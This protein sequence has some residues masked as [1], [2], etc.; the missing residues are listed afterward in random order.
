[1]SSWV[2][3]SGPRDPPDHVPFILVLEKMSW[4]YICSRVYAT[5]FGHQRSSQQTKAEES[6]PIV[7][8]GKAG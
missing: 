8:S 4:R 3:K 2:K 5:E 7:E 1:M 6:D